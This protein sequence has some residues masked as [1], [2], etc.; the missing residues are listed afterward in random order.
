MIVTEDTP[1]DEKLDQNMIGWDRNVNMWEWRMGW[2]GE[3]DGGMVVNDKIVISYTNVFTYSERSP[4]CLQSYLA[5]VENYHL[6][7]VE[8]YHLA[9]VK[10][11][12][13]CIHWRVEQTCGL[14]SATQ[15][16]TVSYLKLDSL[17]VGPWYLYTASH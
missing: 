14:H 6:A 4:N 13:T 11:R 7:L 8:N 12:P 5:L 1:T 3:M 10:I 16:M 9:L 17:R 15:V 2:G